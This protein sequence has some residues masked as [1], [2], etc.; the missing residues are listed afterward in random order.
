MFKSGKLISFYGMFRIIEET[1]VTVA[2]I[3]YNICTQAFPFSYIVLLVLK[4]I[5]PDRKYICGKYNLA[6]LAIQI[7]CAQTMH[8]AKN[9]IVK[10]L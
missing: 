9:V 4:L 10:K 1:A 2:T 8:T 6:C 3:T 5:L 7:Y